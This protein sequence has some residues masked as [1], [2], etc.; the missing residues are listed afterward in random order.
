[1]AVVTVA[2]RGTLDR[3]LLLLPPLLVALCA[4]VARAGARRARSCTPTSATSRRSSPRCCCRGS[5]S[6]RS[7]S[8]PPTSPSNEAVTGDVLRWGNPV[9]PFIDAVRDVLYGGRGAGRCDVLAYVAVAAV[10]A[11]AAGAALFRR[12]G[13]RAGGGRV[14]AGRAR[15]CSSTRRAT[16][17][18]RA[19]PARTLK[20]LLLRRR[21]AGPPPVHALRRRV[22]A[23]RAGRDGRHRRAQRRGQDVD[24][25]R[26]GRDRPAGLRARRSAAGASSRCSS[27]ARASGATSPAARTSCSTA[28]CTACEREEIEARMDDIVAFSE[29]G[30]FIDV[31]VKTYSSGMFVR[32]GFSIAA[33]LDAD[34]L[35][36][37]EVL[38]VGDE[39]FQRKC[40]AR[41]AEQ[42]AAGTTLVLV[43]HDAGADRAHVRAGG[44]ARRRRASCSTGRPP[45]A[46]RSTTADGRRTRDRALKP[47]DA[48]AAAR[49]AAARRRAARRLRRRPRG[50][51]R[52][53]RPTAVTR[54]QLLEWAVIEPDLE[55]SCARRAAL[56][57]PDHLGSSGCCCAACAS[58]TTSSSPSR[59]ASTS[60]LAGLRRRARGPRRAR[61]SGGRRVTVVHQ[62]LS[63]AGPL[64]A[65][66]NA[67]ARAS[68]GCSPTGAGAARDVAARDRPAHERRVAPLTRSRRPRR[69]AAL[70]LLGLRAA[71]ARA[72][73]T[74]PQPQAAALAQRHARRAGSGTTSR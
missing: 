2:V 56:G 69:R 71:A 17:A 64:D 47:E 65:V 63:G 55:R 53:S 1:M 23:R 41:I 14:S 31:P 49:A 30:D 54:E 4:F 58:T 36:I 59:R 15:S 73:S 32:L 18:V 16:F 7:S 72:C 13:A 8:R 39:A 43:S 38:A 12:H 74:L 45:R 61:S 68:A 11:L 21:A 70:P 52:S 34:V 24:A 48:L 42:V 60:T 20:E 6:R 9:A 50:L 57:A 35:L 40:E 46:C 67:G 19:D 33:H 5:S 28:R 25:A 26:A 66:T 37:D 44:R 27:S 51:R 62:V 22:A 3:P 29:L 10:V